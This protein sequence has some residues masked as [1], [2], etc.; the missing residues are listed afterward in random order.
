MNR[1][2]EENRLLR[3]LFR[4]WA[5]Q[6]YEKI[7]TEIKIGRQAF[8]ICPRIDE[9]DLLKELAVEAKSAKK[10][11]KIATKIFPEFEGWWCTAIITKR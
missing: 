5:R 1:Q 8:V 10:S 4:E 9:P 6:I 7:R 11:G 2:S 3:K